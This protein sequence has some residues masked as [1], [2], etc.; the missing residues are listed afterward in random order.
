MLPRTDLTEWVGGS[1]SLMTLVGVRM[2]HL[3]HPT[4]PAS[5]LTRSSSPNRRNSLALVVPYGLFE[6]IRHAGRWV[7]WI[8]AF[9]GTTDNTETT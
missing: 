8:P 2:V 9:A 5:L 4:R 3:R 7:P 6:F 1:R